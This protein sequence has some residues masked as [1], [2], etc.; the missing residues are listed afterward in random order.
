MFAMRWTAKL[1]VLSVGLITRPLFTG[2]VHDSPSQ[3]KPFVANRVMEIQS[4]LDPSVWRYCP[5]PQNPADVPTRG[6]SSN[7]LKESRLWREGPAWLRNSEDE[8]PKDLRSA[9]LS[10]HVEIER[11]HQASIDQ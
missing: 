5:G 1:I 11:K 2:Y 7:E 9:S 6:M 4:L 8:W 3:W 10:E